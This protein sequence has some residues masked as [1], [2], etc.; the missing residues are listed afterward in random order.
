LAVQVEHEE[1][2][3]VLTARL[4]AHKAEVNARDGSGA[5]PLHGA[6]AR[7]HT[8][9]ARLLPTAE[10]DVNA[11]DDYSNTPWYLAWRDGKCRDVA[12]LLQQHGGHC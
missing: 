1:V 12:Q 9:A 3:K 6:A 5:T 11:T 10:A 7:R 2:A 8:D 4:L